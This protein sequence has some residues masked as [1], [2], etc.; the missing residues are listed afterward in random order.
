MTDQE[1]SAFEEWFKTSNIGKAEKHIALAAWEAGISRSKY[2]FPSPGEIFKKDFNLALSGIGI[3]INLREIE[4]LKLGPG[5]L[6]RQSFFSMEEN[7]SPMSQ[8]ISETKHSYFF[9]IHK[10]KSM[11]YTCSRCGQEFER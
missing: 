1:K 8:H 6:V 10:D 7:Q 2:H 3:N 11:F 5:S 9:V 4:H